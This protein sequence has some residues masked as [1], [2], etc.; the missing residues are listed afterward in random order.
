MKRLFSLFIAFAM[1]FGS[2]ALFTSCEYVTG[3]IPGAG[4]VLPDITP[5]DIPGDLPDPD[6]FDAFFV[7]KENIVKK[8]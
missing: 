7:E 4:T 5:D 8:S 2:I 6:A 3:M 1:I